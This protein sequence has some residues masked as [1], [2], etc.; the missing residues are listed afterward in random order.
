MLTIVTG[1]FGASGGS[2]KPDGLTSGKAVSREDLIETPWGSMKRV[3]GDLPCNV[4]PDFIESGDKPIR[5]VVNISGNPLISVPGEARLRRAFAQLDLLVSIDLYRNETAEISDYVLPAT[6]MLE[7]EDVIFAQLG[8]QLQPYIQYT[9]AVTQSR[10][11]RRNDWWILSGIAKAL[12]KPSELDNP[13][14]NGWSVVDHILSKRGLSREKLRSAPHQT[15]VF[16]E[17]REKIFDTTFS[18]IVLHE[19]GKID[20][21]PINFDDAIKECEGL[22]FE[23]ENEAAGTLK[24]ISMRTLYM[25]NSWMANMPQMQRGTQAANLLH[26]HPDDAD[27]RNLR[28][29]Q[30][31]RVFNEFGDLFTTLRFDT[32]LRPGVVCLTHGFGRANAPGLSL[33]TSIPGANV[34]RLFPTGEGSFEK[35]SGMSRMSGVT[36]E[37]QAA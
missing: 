25:H 23:F 13:D 5:A 29:N 15:I 3:C 24:M 1:N 33:A 22:F 37:V 30:P 17:N 26:I 27:T 18:N 19:D 9:D 6:D 35:L 16:P 31:V 21:C 20:C 36:V 11:E 2:F 28:E 32:N 4:L 8:Y 12:G 14:G 34:N 10:H 7:R